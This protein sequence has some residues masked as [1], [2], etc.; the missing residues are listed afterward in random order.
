MKREYYPGLDETVYRTRL[1]SGL[2]V[3]VVPRKGF[4]KKLAYL[5]TD[6]GSVHS[7]FLL[8]GQEYHMPHGVAHFLEHKLFDL[9]G[10]DVSSEFA[11]LGG[12]VNAFTSYDMTAYYV[13][14]SEHFRENLELLL[15][16]VFTPYFTEESVVKEQ[17]IIDQ[18]IG[19][20][21]DA[22]DSR[23]FETLMEGM[24]AHHNIRIPI[25]G[26]SESIRQITPEVL[27]TCHKAFYAPDNM[28]LCVIGDVDAQEVAAIAAARTE[29]MQPAGAVKLAKEQEQMVCRIPR[30]QTVMEV[31][32]PTFQL[33]FKCESV[34][35][36][37]EGIRQE[38]LGD[39]AA[40]AL[41]GESS[42]LY[43]RLY[44]E[45][46]IDSSFGG[47][48]E[49]LDGCAML[50]CGG[51]SEDADGVLQAILDEAQR[52]AREGIGQED[53]LRMKRIA[54]GRR[55]RDLDSF[56]STNF[57]LCACHFSGFDYF[58][59][60]ALYATIEK[61]ELSAFLGRVVTHARSA[62][63]IIT[64]TQG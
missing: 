31:A 60:P 59:F 6:Y 49:T 20:N 8:D 56:D 22:P 44:G 39:L 25:L 53:F 50:T 45:G 13:S 61:E 36:G 37:E 19:M 42:R 30:Q 17:G 10:R 64:P 11:A 57:R 1:A 38:L 46:L 34:P 12:H 63:S 14:C 41:F 24:Y 27:Y 15:E 51:D 7:D 2:T 18:E 28:V 40:E 5:V 52:I 54:M 35:H 26:T 58:R 55:I 48:F 4:S 62:L 9:P 43:L 32:M 29:G 33:G 3:L 16:F 23:I 21:I 47:G